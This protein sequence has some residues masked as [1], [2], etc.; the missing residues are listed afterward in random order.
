[1][2]H[3]LYH[4]FKDRSAALMGHSLAAAVCAGYLYLC[5]VPGGVIAILLIGWCLAE[6]VVLAAEY[7]RRRSYFGAIFSSIDRLDKPYLIAELMPLSRR[8]E[9]RLYRE[10]LYRSGKSVIEEVHRLE[11]EHRE[12]REFIEGW[13]H[14]AKVPLTN[15]SLICENQRGSIFREIR[16][17]AEM[18]NLITEKALF[19]ARLDSVDRDYCIQKLSLRDTALAAIYRHQ[20]YFR[21]NGVCV[22]NDIPE[23]C[24]V[25]CDEK[26]LEFMLCQ[27]FVNAV[28]YRRQG[29]DTAPRIR[30]F[31]RKGHAETI[32]CVEDNGIGIPV[33]E[34]PRIF[35]RGFTGSNGRG[36]EKDSARATGLGLYLCRKLCSRLGLS[37]E[38]ESKE[39]VF[40]R[41]CFHIPDGSSL[42]A[43]G[44]EK[45]NLSNL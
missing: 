8:Q 36:K 25:Y 13:I 22:E 24:T 44:D 37:V 42:F 1:M 34:L 6:A 3:M 20:S 2:N 41:I 35:D 10:I 30:V 28:K 40:T 14:E 23:E 38:A 43:R 39:G 16:E 5:R 7:Y 9:D 4:Y 18:L 26:W 15:L 21:R 32:L 31:A 45:A 19:Y 29:Q 33:Q 17:Q 11:R 27:V 12:Y